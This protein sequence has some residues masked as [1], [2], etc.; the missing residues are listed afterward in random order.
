M[1][2]IIQTLLAPY[3]LSNNIGRH[4]IPDFCYFVQGVRLRAEKR[5]LPAGENHVK[6]GSHSIKKPLGVKAG[7]ICP[8][9]E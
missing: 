5:D 3:F 2:N 7:T 8:R 1:H 6:N 9:E 4:T